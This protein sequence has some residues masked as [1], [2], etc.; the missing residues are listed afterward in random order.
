MIDDGGGEFVERMRCMVII[1]DDRRI[2]GRFET[3]NRNFGVSFFALSVH[4]NF[5]QLMI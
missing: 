1:R 3:R 2:C 4:I 5:F